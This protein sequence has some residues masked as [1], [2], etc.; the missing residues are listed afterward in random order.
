M[1][2]DDCPIPDEY[3]AL[4]LERCD[5]EQVDDVAEKPKPSSFGSSAPSDPPQSYSSEVNPNLVWAEEQSQ[6][7]SSLNTPLDKEEMNVANRF[8]P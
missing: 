2:K 4:T 5:N 3:D 1:L 7:E 8:D 6:I